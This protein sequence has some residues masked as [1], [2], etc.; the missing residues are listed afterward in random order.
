[1][2]THRTLALSC[3]ATLIGS[4]AAPAATAFEARSSVFIGAGQAE[5]DFVV[6]TDFDISETGAP[7]SVSG[8][9]DFGSEEEVGLV[10]LIGDASA[11]ASFGTL[12]TAASGTL[13]NPVVPADF[14]FDLLPYTDGDDVNDEGYPTFFTVDAEAS[15]T[16]TLQY[17]STAVNYS[18]RYGLRLTGNISG[19]AFHFIELQHADNESE[20]FFF[21]TEGPYSLDIVSEAYIHGAFAQEFSIRMQSSFQQDSNFAFDGITGS[22]AFGNTLEVIGIELRDADTGTLLDSSDVISSAPD[23]SY[24]VTEVPEP[25]SLALVAAGLALAT[26]RRR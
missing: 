10:T 21:F 19:D 9:F 16:D 12:R 15:F 3:A 5:E 20:T 18:S 1:M 4:L 26:T 22:A 11:S 25:A 17:G 2:L 6:S 23:Q 8:T 7:V 14:E 24:A 13:F